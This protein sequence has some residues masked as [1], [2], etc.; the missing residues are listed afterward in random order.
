MSDERAAFDD[1]TNKW[2]AR[3]P[4]WAVAEVFVPAV[5]RDTAVAWFA[6]QQEWADAAWGGSDVAPGLAKL[7]WWQEELR[8][9]AKGARR[10]PLGLVLQPL[11]V[12]WTPL[13]L[14][15]P[16]LRA[17]D[18]PA[19]PMQEIEDALA[20]IAIAAA[21][22]EQALF[23]GPVP[24]TGAACAGLVAERMAL[25]AA[26]EALPGLQ[27]RLVQSP[28]GAMAPRQHRAMLSARLDAVLRGRPWQPPSR[29]RSLWNAWRAARN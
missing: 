19:Y 1:F 23:G 27:H 24:A 7:A 3:W 2:R 11:A 17:R 20:G 4:E 29:W 8:G 21:A 16:A 26:P 5:Q 25:A 28:S 14:A 13:A 9:W 10:H 6:L 22:V 12:G 15:L 18:L